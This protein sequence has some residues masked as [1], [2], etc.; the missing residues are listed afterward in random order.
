MKQSI[1]L[2]DGNHAQVDTC[3]LYDCLIFQPNIQHNHVHSYPPNPKPK[4]S[5]KFPK[6]LPRLSTHIDSFK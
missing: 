5:F 3:M 1:S 2:I 4:F 6:K